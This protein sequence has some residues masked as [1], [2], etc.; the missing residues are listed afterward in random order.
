VIEF[1]RHVSSVLTGGDPIGKL[2]G[3]VAV[4]TGGSSGMRLAAARRFVAEGAHVSVTARRQAELDGAV[5]RI[6]REITGVQGDVANPA[7]LDRLYATAAEQKGR[8]DVL[9]ADAGVYRLAPLGSI[10]EE[11]FDTIFGINVRG[12][13]F[14]V[15]KALPLL[16]DG[17]SII[18][19]ASAASIKAVEGVSDYAAGKS[20]VRSFARGWTSDLMGRKICV[21]ALSSGPT[22]T[23]IFE[24]ATGSRDEAEAFKSHAAGMVPRSQGGRG[25]SGAACAVPPSTRLAVGGPKR[26]ALRSDRPKRRTVALRASVSSDRSALAHPVDRAY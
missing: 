19:N 5:E 23:P 16:R 17:G 18:L 6:G 10:T 22:D 13:L 20:A 21:N 14:T 1:N 12:L 11:H 4:I 24:K 26:C 15:Q 2:E 8:I 7:D 25:S 9:F 3:D